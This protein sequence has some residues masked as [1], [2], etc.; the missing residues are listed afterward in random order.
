MRRRTLGEYM[1]VGEAARLQG[2]EGGE[3]P[4]MQ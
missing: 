2:L 4:H 1:K 3:D